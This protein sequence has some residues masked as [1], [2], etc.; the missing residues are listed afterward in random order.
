MLRGPVATPAS[1]HLPKSVTHFGLNSIALAIVLGTMYALRAKVL[2]M[3]ESVLVW[4]KAHQMPGPVIAVCEGLRAP[5]PVLVLCAAVAVPVVLLDIL[6]LR[7]H[8]RETTGL[9]WDNDFSPSLERVVL[10]VA[11]LVLTLAPFAVAYW[12]FPEYNGS[13]YNAYYN[14]LARFWPGLTASAILYV[15]VVDGHMREPRDA[16]WQ[17]GRLLLG[18][19][20]DVDAARVWNH[21]LGWLVKAFFFPLMFVWLN[22]STHN[23]VHFDLT[24]ASWSNLRAYDFL[25]DFIFFIDLLFTTV[26]YALCFRPIDTHLRSAEPT[27]LGWGVA[28][29]CYEPFFSMLFQRQYVDYKGIGFGNWLAQSP[30]FR[31]AWGIGILLLITIYVLATVAFGVRFSNLTHRGI[32]T[33]GPY[34]YTKHPAYV[35]K[36]L[37]WW[38]LSVP[39][40]PNEGAALALKHSL[41]L[42]CVNF[43]YYMRAKT[44]ERHLSRDPVYVEYALWMNEHGWLRFLNRIPIAKHL[45]VYKPPTGVPFL[46]P[47]QTRYFPFGRPETTQPETAKTET[48]KTE[49][50]QPGATRPEAAKPEAA[51]D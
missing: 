30:Q 17:L 42:L 27:F 8:R 2:G 41:L 1:H 29:F 13:F 14:L 25:Y 18:K 40:V 21:Y 38:M 15:T 31:W 47:I 7:V 34:R 43:I 32:L 4:C 20:R 6:V 36:N 51:H 11:G 33:N 50:P 12:A 22:N 5:D 37:S 45:F 35:S 10:K 39:F 26:G 44:E 23:V 49:E 46:V 48:A 24:T 28:L 9:D 19:W 3:P 16:Y